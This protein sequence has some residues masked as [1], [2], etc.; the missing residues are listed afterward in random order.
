MAAALQALPAF[1][2]ASDYPNRPVKIVVGFPPGGPPDLIARVTGQ[3]VG[4][5]WKQPLIVHNR[6]GA[7]GAIGA[8]IVAKAA[9]DGYTLLLAPLTFA[10]IPN[11]QKLPYDTAKDFTPVTV[12]AQAPLVLVAHPS[13]KANSVAELIAL[14]KAKPG[15]MSYASAGNGTSPHII[16]EMFKRATGTHVVHIPYRGSPAAVQDVLAGRAEYY[17]DTLAS[18]LPHI[19]R[20]ALKPLAV[21]SAKRNTRLPN[22]PTLTEVGLKGFDVEGW[23][24][25]FAPAGIPRP[26]LVT[27]N[28][29]FNASLNTPEVQQRIA[30]IGAEPVGMTPE[31]FER[32][33]KRDMQRFG[34]IIK[35]VGI[36]LD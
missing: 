34:A 31:E 12:L 23:I 35:E 9:P 22:V 32:I 17:F 33:L 18:A 3:A 1:G 11:L 27:I 2:Q 25:I 28:A 19:E 16:G 13:V 15:A 8:D 4:E 26:L 14:A 21:L 5:R 10:I 20:G 6:G 36:K 24:G 7:S 29:A 30:A